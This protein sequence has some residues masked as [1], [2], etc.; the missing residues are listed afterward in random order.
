MSRNI[1]IGDKKKLTKEELLQKE[2]LKKNKAN[3][4][5]NTITNR[6]KE[7]L[8]GKKLKY[9][10]K[11]IQYEEIIIK[12][13]SQINSVTGNIEFIYFDSN[14]KTHTLKQVNKRLIKEGE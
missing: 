5:F 8:I 3:G 12:R 1:L 4:Y 7:P 9:K 2:W 6:K 13:K 10:Y 14:E 11:N